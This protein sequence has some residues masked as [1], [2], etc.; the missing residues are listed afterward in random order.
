[1]NERVLRDFP[2]RDGLVIA[3]D[4]DKSS[5][6]SGLESEI[7][8]WAALNKYAVLKEYYTAKSQAEVTKQRKERIRN[9][10]IK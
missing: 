10:L 7:D 9:E 4:G 2:Q 3:Q 8:E 1:M 5:V 6:V